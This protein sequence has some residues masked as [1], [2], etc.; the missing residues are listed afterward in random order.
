M[1]EIKAGDLTIRGT[2]TAG[3]RTS[4]H[5]PQLKIVLDAGIA[6]PSFAKEKNILLSHCH[7][8]H[9]GALLALLG[10]RDLK[11]LEAPRVWVPMGVHEQV[12][13]LVQLANEM[14]K[15]SEEARVTTLSNFSMSL[16]NGVEVTA[17]DTH[18][19]VPSNGYVFRTSKKKLKPEYKGLKGS[20]IAALS[21]Q[22]VEVNE[23]VPRIRLAYITDTTSEVWDSH[24]SNW[25]YTPPILE[26]EVL[27][28]EC[29]FLDDDK[30]I[31]EARKHGHIHLDEI[32]AA[33]DRFKNKH[34]VLMHF[35]ARYDNDE[36]QR[37]VD[38]KLPASLRERVQLL[39]PEDE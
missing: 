7:M 26:A 33:A 5:V 38:E 37:K 39:L 10:N 18:H 30:P 13:G 1:R 12:W 9:V 20:D 28:M 36:I 35:S 16:G 14:G 4:L 34:I 23:Q 2:S 19:A 29:T 32:A 3:I 25:N 24:N 15:F 22:G 6:H 17:F 8:D 11:R 31:E 27:V 21:K